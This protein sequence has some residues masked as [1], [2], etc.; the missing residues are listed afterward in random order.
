M[1][2]MESKVINDYVELEILFYYGYIDDILVC[3]PTLYT[4]FILDKFNKFHPNLQFTLEESLENS[5]NFLDINNHL[6][7]DAL[8]TDI[9][10]KLLLQVFIKFSIIFVPLNIKNC[11]TSR[12]F[13]NLI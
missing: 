3:L 8:V 11:L 9:Y 6:C 10:R 4:N 5:I 1:F 7:I 2:H 12:S 13:S